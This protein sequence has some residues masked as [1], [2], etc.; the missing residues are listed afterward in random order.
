LKN[1]PKRS[2]PGHLI[3]IFFTYMAILFLFGIFRMILLG[4][5][6]SL[7][8]PENSKFIVYAVLNRGWLF[9]TVT[10][11]YILALPFIILNISYLTGIYH[12]IITKIAVLITGLM[13]GIAVLLSLA[14][15]PYYFYYN[16]R[17]NKGILNWTDDLWLMVKVSLSDYHYW[18]YLLAF[19]VLI[20]LIFKGI[21]IL[22]VRSFQNR[23]PGQP[24]WQRIL[25]FVAGMILLFFGARGEYHLNWRPLQVEHAF[26][27]PSPVMNQL[28]LNPVFNFLHSLSEF[29]INVMDDK[30]AIANMRKYLHVNQSFSSPIAR[31]VNFEG[32]PRKA[33]IIIVL[34]E[35]MSTSKMGRFQPG[36]RLTPFLDSLASVSTSFDNVY[37]AGVHTYNGVF[38]TL[39]GMPALMKNKPTTS[40]ATASL[41]FAGLP[42]ILEKEGYQNIFFC[43]NAKEFD[44]LEGFFRGNGIKKVI[45]EKDFP[46]STI[47]N[48]WGVSDHYLFGQSMYR[49]DSMA[50]KE[51]PFFATFLTIA[52][53]SP[54]TIPQNI[55]F[56]PESS[57]VVDQAYEYADW[58]IRQFMKAAAIKPWFANTIFV[59]IGDHGQNFDKTY[60]MPLSYH[61]SPL[62]IY[63]PWDKEA[64]TVDKPGLQIDV[65]PTV[66][67]IL[68]VPYINNTLGIDLLREHRPFAFFSDDH[69]LG[70]LNDRYYLIINKNGREALYSYRD[71]GIEDLS[72]NQ[73]ELVDSMKQY[74]Y[75][76]L[77][78][79]QYLIRQKLTAL[80]RR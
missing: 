60:E 19:P 22:S 27:T 49:L 13:I 66:L 48:G 68:Q 11:S 23:R 65:F 58:S 2:F 76:N 37:T 3:F 55:P 28:G 4:M 7:I 50:A 8:T 44:N 20:Y 74:T 31:K 40:S 16:S 75:S 43:P 56:K 18:P 39:Y 69:R 35:S 12:K 10:A 1:H 47:V 45:D 15:I 46:E 71:K 25:V 70:C 29:E 72:G 57:D 53:H 51:R 42:N 17:L 21:R 36:L 52:T 77:Q 32:A 61:H 14:D 63:K 62:I 80:P 34:M 38:S 73:K 30:Q 6:A 64:K 24:V 33:N 41:T 5:Q 78:L 26:K 9:D 67:G 59:F 79:M 54:F